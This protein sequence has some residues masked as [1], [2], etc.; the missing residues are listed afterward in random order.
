MEYSCYLKDE[1][2]TLLFGEK[3]GRVID[4][5]LLICLDGDLG[6]GKTCLTKGIAKGLDIEEEI[7]SPTFILVEEY[8][9]R[10]ALYHFDVYRIDDPEELYFIGFDEY[11]SK[12]AVVIIEWASLIEEVLPTER[13]DITIEYMKDGGRKVS[14]TAMGEEARNVLQRL[15]SS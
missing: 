5:R 8:S 9:G 11:L 10:M 4:E 1:Q 6:A 7:T 2:E 15:I 12:E 14:V 3:L 13:L